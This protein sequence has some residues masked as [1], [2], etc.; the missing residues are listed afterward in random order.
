[1]TS[2]ATPP[3]PAVGA[4]RF[5]AGGAGAWYRVRGGADVP[6]RPAAAGAATLLVPLGRD[7]GIDATTKLRGHDESE[8]DSIRMLQAVAPTGWIGGAVLMRP[9]PGGRIQGNAYVRPRVPF[10]RRDSL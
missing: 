2:I 4:A 10:V 6:R 5:W 8:S 3:A 1:M 7:V 9:D